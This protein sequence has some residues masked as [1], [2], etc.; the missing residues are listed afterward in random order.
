MKKAIDYMNDP[1]MAELEGEPFEVRQVHA[2]RLEAQDAKKGMDSIQLRDY[3]KA[4]RAE[5]DSFCAKH[6]F[7][8]KYADQ[9]ETSL[10]IET[11][12]TDDEHEIIA[13]SVR[14]YHKHP[15]NFVTLDSIL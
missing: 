15:E 13:D 7:H 2:W 1:R 4:M 12:L 10:V 9:N 14:R 11:D 8:L 3:Y 6:G 5:T